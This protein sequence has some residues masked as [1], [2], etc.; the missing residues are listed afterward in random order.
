MS[1]QSLKN[2]TE[3]LSSRVVPSGIQFES[4]K[5]DP[6]IKTAGNVEVLE[7]SDKAQWNK[8]LDHDIEVEELRETV[9]S[10]AERVARL[11]SAGDDTGGVELANLREFDDR[12]AKEEILKLFSLKDEERLFYSDIS[13]ALS[14]DIEQVVRVCSLL[15]EEGKLEEDDRD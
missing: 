3:T 8:I 7:E 1:N 9:R 4:L 15:E 13:S 5:A 12:E 11:E 14:M 10:L 2:Y 6:P